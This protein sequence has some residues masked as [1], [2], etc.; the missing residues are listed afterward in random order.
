MPFSKCV[1]KTV[2]DRYFSPKSKPTLTLIVTFIK[3]IGI[4]IYFTEISQ[5]SHRYTLLPYVFN[6][7]FS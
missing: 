7:F 5:S 2:V 3:Y 1:L 4:Y 6:L